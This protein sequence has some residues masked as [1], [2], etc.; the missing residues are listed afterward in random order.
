MNKIYI[1]EGRFEISWMLNGRFHSFND[2]PS[3]FRMNSDHFKMWH[4]NGL[5]HRLT[6]P[7]IEFANGVVQYWIE[8]KRFTKKQFEERVRCLKS[9]K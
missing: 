2:I 7:A 9:T 8:G 5:C 3:I 1:I 6:G 4:K